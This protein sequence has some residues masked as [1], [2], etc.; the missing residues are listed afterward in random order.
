[1]LR[2][3]ALIRYR[4]E[5]L[6][7]ASRWYS[8]LLG[9][10]PYFEVPGQYVEF[11]LGDYSQ[12]LGIMQAGN[13]NPSGIVTYW[14]VDNVEAFQEKLLELGATPHEPLHDFGH[15]FVAGSVLDPFGN[16]FGFMYNPHYVEMLGNTGVAAGER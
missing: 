6:D 14:H 13:P 10:E 4:A 8:R 11:R 5:D 16:V 15:G 3:M 12:E 2:G 9:F 1:M 7:A